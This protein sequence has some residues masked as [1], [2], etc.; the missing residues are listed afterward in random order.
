M[1]LTITR[2]VHAA[3]TISSETTSI[4]VDP[5]YFGYPES[6]ESADAVLVT[7]NHFDHVDVPSLAASIRAHP[8]LKVFSPTPL[9]LDAPDSDVTLVAEGDAFTVGDIPVRVV[10]KEQARASLDDGVIPNVGYLVAGAVL[11]PGDAHQDCEGVD[12]LLTALAAPW[13]NN[14]QLEEYLRR[15]RPK[16]VIGIHDATLN[17]LGREFAQKTL[18]R[19]AQSYGGEA[20]A[21]GTGDSITINVPAQ[22]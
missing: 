2:G 15:V 4:V 14:P 20:V 7:H 6:V 19:I 8:Q 9:S 3:V 22:Q 1:Q 21:L 17:D 10:G 12:T 16:R 5:G 11:H 18:A 13:Q